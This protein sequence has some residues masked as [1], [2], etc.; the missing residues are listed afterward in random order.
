M[1]TTG[2]IALVER[3]YDKTPY[4]FKPRNRGLNK[5]ITI[6]GAGGFLGNPLLRIL[7]ANGHRVTGLRSRDGDICSLRNEQLAGDLVIHLAA[8]AFV[9]D[10][11]K[12]PE[13]TYRVNAQGTLRVLEACRANQTPVMLISTYAYGEPQYLPIDEAHPIGA[14]NPYALSKLAAEN[15]ALFYQEA[16][17]LPV[18]IVRPF[19]PYGPGQPSRFL[20]PEILQQ[21]ADPTCETV[22]LLDLTPRRDLLY[23][24]DLAEAIAALIAS[25]TRGIF[26]VGSGASASVE[27]IARTAMKVAGVE[28]P[29]RSKHEPRVQEISDVVADC[30]AI[31][32][33]CGWAPRT[34]L[35]AGLAQM[36]ETPVS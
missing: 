6:T 5:Q 10:S 29:L 16:F 11:W 24:D 7:E 18:T 23:I 19:N 22:T 8:K 12:D 21:I 28:K 27:E 30:T 4:N 35:E 31:R 34:S 2:K 1:S 26:N 14:R 25:G 32:D 13:E 15:A 17:D 20:I 33:A 9:P 3:R 36:L